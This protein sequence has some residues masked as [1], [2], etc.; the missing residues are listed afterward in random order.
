MTHEHE[1]DVE[2]PGQDG[3]GGD[4]TAEGIGVLSDDEA[5]V[6]GCLVEKQMTTPD[7]YPMSLNGV[8]L[9]A[10]QKSNRDPVVDL[11]EGTVERT[12]RELTDRGLARMVHRPGDRVVKYRHAID[13][14]LGLDAERTSLLAVLLLRGAQTPG[15]LRQRTQRYVDFPS[16]IDVERTLDRLVDAGLVVRL[17]RRP[18]QKEARV[19]DLVSVRGRAVADGA[20]RQVSSPGWSGGAADDPGDD[21]E[22]LRSELT[23]LRGR[24]E[25]LL[26]RLGVDDL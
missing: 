22:E 15:E 2:A 25:E 6:V 4:D 23:D 10:N 3:F 7:Q 26:E 13:E 12:L 21:L 1:P 8:T 9:A 5:R 11:S 14:R 24:F 18:G 16:L 17:E 20:E 19:V